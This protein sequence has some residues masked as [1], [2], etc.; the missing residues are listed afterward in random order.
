MKITVITP[1]E[2]KKRTTYWI[3]KWESYCGVCGRLM[4]KE[5]TRMYTPRPDNWHE[6]VEIEENTVCYG[7]Y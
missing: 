2:Y 1:E 5:W 7:C 3:H 6:R 4:A